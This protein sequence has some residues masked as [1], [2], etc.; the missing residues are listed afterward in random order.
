MNVMRLV[1]AIA[2]CSTAFGTDQPQRIKLATLLP[3]GS[4]AHQALLEMGEKWRQA[5][6][7]GVT[8][9]IYTDG[10]MGGEAETVS[11]QKQD[12]KEFQ[13]L[14]ERAV[15]IDV[16]AK[17]GFRLANLIMQRRA[18]WLLSRADQ[19]FLEVEE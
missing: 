13:S 18:R 12:R 2:F 19:L 16:N 5:P 17:P 15:A 9:T 1:I 14:L 11:V 4:S 6:G 10:T 7:A 3:K 8:L